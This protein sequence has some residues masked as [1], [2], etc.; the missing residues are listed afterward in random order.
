M[1]SESAC[2]S[3][4]ELKMV[5]LLGPAWTLPPK[6]A[7]VCD[8]H[9]FDID[10]HT[11]VS[12]YMWTSFRERTIFGPKF[13]HGRGMSVPQCLYF[14]D[15]ECLTEVIDWMSAGISNLKLPLWADVLFL[16][17]LVAMCRRRQGH[18]ASRLC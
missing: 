1:K 10:M 2:T 8:H 17:F 14:Q 13:C 12:T 3:G 15:L 9:K 4:G 16:I 5:L 6:Y 18:E 11:Q 7:K